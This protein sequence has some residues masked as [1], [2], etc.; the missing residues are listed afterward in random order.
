MKKKGRENPRFDAKC[1][2]L[3]PF[4]YNVIGNRETKR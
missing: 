3:M 4:N 2:I 1:V